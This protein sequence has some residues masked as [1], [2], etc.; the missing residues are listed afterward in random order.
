MKQMLPRENN[1]A[2]N[3][4]H[5]VA[6]LPAAFAA[7]LALSECRLTTSIPLSSGVTTRSPITGSALLSVVFLSLDSL[8]RLSGCLLLLSFLR[9]A[10]DEHVD[11]DV[12]LFVARNGVTK[13]ED[14]ASK[15]VI[16][17]RN[18][19]LT[20]S[21]ARNGNVDATERGIG[22]GKGN[23]GGVHVGR[24]SD[25]LMVLDRVSDEDDARLNIRWL[26]LVSEGTRGIAT[27]NVAT[28]KVLHKLEESALRIRGFYLWN[29]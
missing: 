13:T 7:S 9:V 3:R 26:R 18:G 17:E 25:G 2:Q 1:G 22:V 21:V 6:L 27:S 24:L 12:P 19:V 29:L 8:G 10:V 5:E 11:H 20:L 16:H 4:C 14:F 28:T 15:E 23:D